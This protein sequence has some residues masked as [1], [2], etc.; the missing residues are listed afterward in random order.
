MTRLREVEETSYRGWQREQDG[1]F[2]VGLA[3]FIEDRS[4]ARF[5]GGMQ[6]SKMGL[7]TTEQLRRHNQEKKS[8]GR[9]GNSTDRHVEGNE[10]HDLIND[11]FGWIE[12]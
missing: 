3:R 5:I 1:Q 10:R 7:S 11:G 9:Q 2:G 8:Q 4:V 6:C 12:D